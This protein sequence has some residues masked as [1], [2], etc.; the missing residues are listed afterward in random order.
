MGSISPIALEELCA[1]L[2]PG[3]LMITQFSNDYEQY[4]QR[5]SITAEKKADLIIVPTCKEDIAEIVKYVAA[6]NIEMVVCC[7]GHSTSGSSSSDGGLVIDLSR[8]RNVTVD[9][10][11][12]T[13]IAQGGCLWKDVDDEATKYNLACVGGT[14][15]HTG[16]GGLTLGGGYGYLTSKHG[17]VIDNLLEVEMVLADG[18]IVTASKTE[19]QDLFWAV[20]GAGQNFGVATSFKYQAHVQNT[21]VWI[22]ILVFNKEQIR[23][24]IDA[25]NC[26]QE[27]GDGTSTVL[28]AF[29]ALPPE[30]KEHGMMVVLFYNGIGKDAEVFFQPMLRLDALSREDSVVSYPTANTLLNPAVT[31]G[32]RRTMKGSATLAPVDPELAE[33][34]FKDFETFM[35]ETPDAGLSLVIFEYFSFKK[36]ISVPQTATSFTNR[37]ALVPFVFALGWNDEKNDSPCRDWARE[38]YA[39]L[40]ARLMQQISKSKDE[41]TRQGVGEYINHDSFGVGAKAAYGV[42]HDRLVFLKKKYDP[43]NVFGHGPNSFI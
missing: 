26:L 15:N 43:G 29:C 42:N 33:E 1:R 27:A 6:Y 14:V 13:V 30:R 5:W 31:H 9:P 25:A 23:D 11:Q 20:R 37:G 7:G 22:S 36:I 34:M 10:N 21:S 24:V 28:A 19:N 17:L 4:L 40:R 38:M 32:H 3:A 2:S 18:G 41:V 39:K 35:K 8:L 12:R 16:V